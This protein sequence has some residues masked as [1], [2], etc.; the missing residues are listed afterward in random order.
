MLVD[1]AGM[2]AAEMAGWLLIATGVGFLGRILV[3][4]KPFF[5]LWGDAVVGLIGVFLVGTL[6]RAFNFDLTTWIDI[7]ISA[8]LGAILIRAVLRPFTG[9]G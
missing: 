5:G 4:G 1:Y 7:A 6:M 2:N 9:S 3:K 8:L